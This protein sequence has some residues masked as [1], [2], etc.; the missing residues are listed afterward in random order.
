M[1]RAR[2]SQLRGQAEIS[3]P[4]APA[5]YF[6][7]ALAR[8]NEHIEEARR[9]VNCF[10]EYCFEHY[11]KKTKESRP[12][13]QGWMHRQWQALMSI[14]SRLLI[15][16]PRSHGK[17]NQCI[18]RSLYELG[19]D[20]NHLIKIIS[21]SDAKAVKRL[22]MIRAHMKDNNRLHDVFPHL[23]LEEASEANK[24]QVTVQRSARM[25]D[26]SIEA[27][28]ITSSAS[29]D[30]AT[31]LL[32]DDVVDRRNSITL[33][34]VRQQIK[35]AW[36]DW[37][38]LL[39]GDGGQIWYIATLWHQAALTHDLMANSEWAVAW[40]EITK[41]MGCLVRVP[42]GREHIA[43]YPLWGWDPRCKI[44]L[45]PTE[46]LQDDPMEVSVD[47]AAEPQPEPEPEPEP[48]PAPAK[49]RARCQCGPWTTANLIRRRRE[50]GPRKFARGFSNKP[51]S[52]GELKID[53]KW[54]REYTEEPG[55]DWIW[56]MSVDTA[57]SQGQQ[58]AWTGIVI[59]AV[60][61]ENG[62]LRIWDAFHIKDKFPA[63]VK[64]II[65]LYIEH[66]FSLVIIERGGGGISLIE[67]LIETTSIPLFGMPTK[68][69]GGHSKD[70]RL[71]STT[72]RLAN[73]QITFA[74]ELNPTAG[75]VG[76]VRGD[77]LSELL[78]W[79]TYPTKDI[80]DA[81]A[82]LARYCAIKHP[83]SVDAGPDGVNAGMS[84]VARPARADDC[85]TVTLIG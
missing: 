25:A 31:I 21:Q 5:P 10:I 67:E 60:N 77:L 35:D 19:C 73:G 41:E 16:A 78:E 59:A 37:V 45:V 56:Y 46:T 27:L 74:P 20:A 11:N 26:P 51:M 75:L 54:I 52:E 82:H 62:H 83:C 29:G 30:R 28:G 40:Y 24:H 3:V 4:T 61:P 13:V 65:D 42:D 12:F 44:H 8:K 68:T 50:L 9:D 69:K 76:I 66:Q 1:P 70:E 64:L 23:Q 49:T 2:S 15:I 7:D 34:K 14:H 80:A 6:A 58:A 32:A 36:D 57:E 22:T 48:E 72:P 33:P 55:D 84:L 79:G 17:T 53:P 47:G 39:G 71:E 85:M 81:F 18:A 43:T 38:N 63:R